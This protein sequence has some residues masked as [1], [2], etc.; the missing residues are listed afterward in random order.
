AD[1]GGAILIEANLKGAI[2]GWVNSFFPKTSP[3]LEIL[4]KRPPEG[5]SLSEI[6]ELNSKKQEA[7]QHMIDNRPAGLILNLSDVY[8][9]GVDLSGM[10][11]Y[12]LNLCRANLDGVNMEESDLNQVDLSL[13]SLNGANLKEANLYEV[14][15]LRAELKEAILDG[16]ILIGGSQGNIDLSG[17]KLRGTCLTGGNQ[18]QVNMENA[19]LSGACLNLVDLSSVN[20]RLTKLTG[21]KLK[22]SV[23]SAKMNLQG[24]EIEGPITLGSDINT[25]Y[26]VS[27][28][29]LSS[30][31]WNRDSLDIWFN[32]INNPESGS[33]LTTIDS[34]DGDEQKVSLVSQLI[35]LLGD[36]DV[37]TVALPL[38]SILTKSPYIDNTD[39]AIWLDKAGIP[40][41]KQYNEAVMPPMDEA[42][43]N[44]IEG[45]FSRQPELKFTA[46][47]AFIQFVAQAVT[48]GG[49]HNKNATALYDSYLEDERVKPYV[50]QEDFGDFDR[51]ADWSTPHAMN[52]I[53]LSAQENSE[54]VMMFSKL[55]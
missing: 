35:Q 12:G 47:A 6:K 50:N 1:M 34:I 14:N 15:L 24:V 8:L 10:Q 11:L 38:L 7:L 55:L 29:I 46:N 42:F 28:L 22:D 19:D 9:A 21:V 25:L 13:A 17:A 43:L 37:S 4:K 44:F 27:I 16:A 2:L 48:A 33:L 18:C 51:K 53:L 3:E 49:D 52:F 41:L 23:I 45:T 32:H 31:R 36:T 30:N 20:M 40:Y 26:G 5:C 39:I 54:R